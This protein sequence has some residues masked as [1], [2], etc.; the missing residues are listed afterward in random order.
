MFLYYTIPAMNIEDEI[1]T[2]EE[3]A[4]Y[5]R[6]SE[7]T[8]SDWAQKGEIPAGKLGTVWRFKKED[9]EKWV[10]SRLS[11]QASPR[12]GP[13][14]CLENILSPERISFLKQENK[15]NALRSLAGVLSSAPQVKNRQELIL[16]I[17]KRDELMSTAIGQ[18]IAIPHVRLG[19]VT[20]LV[21]AVGICRTPILDFE[22]LDNEPVR[23]LIMLAASYN[24][25]AYYL[26]S[27]SYFCVRL[28]NPALKEGLLGSG[29]AEEAYRLLIAET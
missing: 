5:L 23:I 10:S 6:V 14:V 22:A 25:H 27:L 24:Q 28:K 20:D 16:E 9:I 11:P 3:V 15:H 1:L 2:I 19:S 12:P 13:K 7:R 8:V 26:Q 18:G 29:T 17:L 21:A 4:R